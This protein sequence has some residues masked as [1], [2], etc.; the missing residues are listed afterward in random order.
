MQSKKKHK[1]KIKHVII[2]TSDAVD[3]NATQF[4]IRPKVLQGL[5]IALC[6]VIGA[7][8]GYFVYEEKIWEAAVTT[9]LSQAQTIEQLKKD[10]E[11]L[12]LEKEAKEAELNAEIQSLNDKIQILSETVN[13]KV[14]TEKE[15]TEQLEK[16]SLP[17]EF[18][19][20]GSASMEEKTDS[21]N[22]ICIFTA[23]EG[24]AVVATAKGTVI[25]VNDDVEYG[26]N[27]WIDHGNGYVTIYR[28]QGDASVKQG[29]LV[30]Q[31]TTLFEIDKDNHILGYQMMKDGIYINPTDML[32]IS[33]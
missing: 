12:L 3:D 23:S 2:V 15:L 33:G 17:R 11:I 14:A 24:T 16:L 20:T 18:P 9:N 21:P 10:N 26:H 31:G 19:L 5:V 13:Q 29:D 7:V 1:R 32:I 27:V 8:I 22:P 6:I 25:A 30:V 28:N 4:R